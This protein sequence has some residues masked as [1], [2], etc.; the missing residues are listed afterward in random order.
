MHHNFKSLAVLGGSIHGNM[1][2]VEVGEDLALRFFGVEK[3]SA[4]YQVSTFIFIYAFYIL[5]EVYSGQLNNNNKPQLVFQIKQIVF[6]N[7]FKT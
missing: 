2:C 7:M 4:G 1:Y 5:R 6:P 3:F